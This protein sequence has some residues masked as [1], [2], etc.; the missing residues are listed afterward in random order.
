MSKAVRYELREVAGEL[1]YVRLPDDL[2]LPVRAEGFLRFV[3]GK[4]K[5]LFVE[6]RN[7]EILAWVEKKVVDIP[8]RRV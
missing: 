2:P 7:G 4:D 8:K 1:A 6:V 5:K 3:P